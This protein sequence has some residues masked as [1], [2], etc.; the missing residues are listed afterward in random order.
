MRRKFSIVAQ[1]GEI[2]LDSTGTVGR[3]ARD[4]QVAAASVK[5]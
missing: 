3:C 1:P 5:N 4:G 2:G